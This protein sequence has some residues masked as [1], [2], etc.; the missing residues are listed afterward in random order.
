M[1]IHLPLPSAVLLSLL[2]AASIADAQSGKPSDTP[3]PAPTVSPAPALPAP[4]PLPEINR[5]I[6]STLPHFPKGGGYSVSRQALGALGQSITQ[7]PKT[8]GIL[9]TPKKS[10][11]SFCSGATYL[12]LL[13]TLELLSDNRKITLTPEAW[14]A[15]AQTGQADGDGIWG[16]WNANG[17]GTAKFLHDLKAG[18][19]FSNFDR[20]LPG[21]FMKIWWSMEIGAK[22]SGHSVI[23]L[24]R[25][26]E[27]GEEMVRFWSSNIP[28]GFGEK[29][30]PRTK[31]KRVLFT[32]LTRPENL[33]I[34][35][36]LP[37]QDPFLASMLKRSFLWEEVVK[38][39]AVFE[40]R[41]Q[42]DLKGI[43]PPKAKAVKE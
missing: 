12:V 31:V 25:T 30:I 38:E 33:A 21:D 4:Q 20:A 17:P 39:C 1:K 26:V 18:T 14:K 11:P 16:R 28:D 5:L 29:N 24:G 13:K 15:Y 40:D 37:K 19:N 10:T 36:R 22:E 3:L 41:Q 43:T 2:L 23:Y 9:V 6:L 42:I 35:A 27:N 8:R 32:R 7:N 34:T